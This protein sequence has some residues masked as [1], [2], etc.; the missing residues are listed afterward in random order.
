ML[1]GFITPAESQPLTVKVCHTVSPLVTVLG[2]VTVS[3][4]PQ[5]TVCVVVGVTVELTIKYV[6]N[7]TQPL[8]HE[9]L[10]PMIPAVGVISINTVSRKTTVLH[11]PLLLMPYTVTGKS[12]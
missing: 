7:G 12:P 1:K 4:P 2:S 8:I 5:I 10:G 3:M 6:V 9:A 11:A